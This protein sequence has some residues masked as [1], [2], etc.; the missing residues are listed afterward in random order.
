M[1]NKKTYF[2]SGGGTGGHIYPA[3]TI[4]EKLLKEEDTEKVYF[5]G[6][7]ENLEYE[8]SK[9]YPNINFLP[10][11]VKGMPRKISF[12][13]IKWG[14]Q[15]VTAI[16]KTMGY[17]KKYKPNAIFA[18]GGYV[19][20]PLILASVLLKQPYMIHD[21]DSVPGMVS[22]I[23]APKAKIVS[24]AFKNAENILKSSNIIYNGNPI[25][26]AF[27]FVTKETA[28]NHLNI[29]LDKQV[30]FAMGGSQG[31]KTINTA[32]TEILKALGNKNN[33]F[34]ILQTGKKNYEEVLEELEKIY[35]EYKSNKN[36]LIK[37]YFDEM[38]Y[39]LKASDIVISRAGSV[40]L[41]EI[42]QC[43]AASI[44]I[45]YP[46][47]A[48]DHQRKNAKEMCAKGV[49]LYLE[50]SDCNLN[51]LSEKINE[52]ISNSKKLE[53]MQ[54]KTKEFAKTNPAEEIVKQLKSIIK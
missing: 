43:N 4:A 37:P 10:V 20:A 16:I 14:I 12:S 27:F 25:R 13:F 47:A 52:L 35:P 34:I 11:M 8:I 33:L 36:I 28:R 21:C 54:T 18:T 7:P 1:S 2:I 48:Q 6:N 53:L 51:N 39:P 3:F 29:S 50:D 40:S 22:K 31:A 15:L 30:I 26:E 9:Q 41:S 23:A 32:M 38:V 24:I 49:S 42:L 17:V 44:L 5:I 45:P 19:S 46:Y